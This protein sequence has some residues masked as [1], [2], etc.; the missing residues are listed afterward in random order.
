VVRSK[1]NE[2]HTRPS[3]PE[4]KRNCP[5]AFGSQFAQKY[6]SEP[7]RRGGWRARSRYGSVLRI[8][9]RKKYLEKMLAISTVLVEYSL[10]TELV[11]IQTNEKHDINS[12]GNC[13]AL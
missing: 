6:C 4:H 1:E 11:D 5:A 13:S 9:N 3:L 8:S 10:H 12:D 7:A 2:R